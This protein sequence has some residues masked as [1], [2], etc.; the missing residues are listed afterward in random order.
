MKFFRYLSLRAKRGFSLKSIGPNEARILFDTSIGAIATFTA[1]LYCFA[2]LHF[3]FDTL[4][5]RIAALPVLQVAV[6]ALAGVYSRLKAASGRTKALVLSGCVT[7]TALIA[8]AFI[9]AAFVALWAVADFLPIVLS[10]LLLSVQ[11]STLRTVRRAAENDR[12]PVLV[13][14]GAGYIGTH[15]VDQL[16]RSG[17]RVRV[18]DRLMYGAQTLTAFSGNRRFEFIEGDAAN[19]GKLTQAMRGAQSVV[20]LA[21]LVGD[22]ACAVD[23]DF[24]RQTNI[25]VTRMVRQVA[26]ASGVYRFIFASSCSVYGFTE[27]EVDETDAL[28]PVSL[29]ARTKIDS[30]NELLTNVPDDFYVTILRFATVFGH[31]LRPRYDL[32]ANLF[33]AQAVRDNLITVQGPDQWRPF[34]HVRDL[35]RAVQLTLEADPLLIQSQ[36]FNVGDERL[37]MTIGQ[38]AETVKA[39]VGEHVRISV[40]DAVGDPRNYAV[41]FKK[42]NE[43]L[44]FRASVLM[45]GGVAEIVEVL[46]NSGDDYRED[47][48]S[49]VKM[50]HKAVDHFKNAEEL[51]SL[52]GPLG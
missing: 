10:R 4:H 3:T 45:A 25:V 46:K 20:H 22:P 24:T 38:L 49:N 35:A 34:V 47:V 9:P 50:T 18:L 44:G 1:A 12:G 30:E 27:K 42:I 32:V 26:Q 5:W 21:G 13:I 52:Y 15:V 39:V 29:Y 19:I 17:Y 14:G 16:L 23:S 33:A 40:S 48:F 6:L 28:N 37:N 2:F 36:I 43:A 8:L 31:S 11:Q 51:A 7:T 41:S